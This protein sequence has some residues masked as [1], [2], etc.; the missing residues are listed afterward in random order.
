[1]ELFS[2]SFVPLWFYPDWLYA[3]SAC[4]PF[5]L[6]FFEPI[7][8]FLGRYAVEDMLQIV[9]LQLVW[10]AVLY[11]AGVWVWSKAQTKVM[12]HGG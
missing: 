2:G 9:L 7:S 3:I 6:I 12:V 10:L 4:L 8:I 11:A 1:M 5:R